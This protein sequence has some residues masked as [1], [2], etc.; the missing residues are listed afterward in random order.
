MEERINMLPYCDE[1]VWAGSQERRNRLLA[2]A[3]AHRL[4]RQVQQHAPQRSHFHLLMG[5]LLTAFGVRLMR[6]GQRLQAHPHN[7]QT[8]AQDI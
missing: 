8:N 5:R 3:K 1:V 2:E 7:L 6:W 4:V